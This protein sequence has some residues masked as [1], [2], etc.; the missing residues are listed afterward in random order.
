MA[1]E[2]SRGKREKPK[3]RERNSRRHGKGESLENR[4]IP[5]YSPFLPQRKTRRKETP[6]WPAKERET[7][8][9]IIFQRER[10][11][12]SLSLSSPRDLNNPRVDSIL[13]DCGLCPTVDFLQCLTPIFKRVP[14]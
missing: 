4:E 5:F 2:R 3:E 8:R 7:E 1:N 11:R 12:E 13:N 14:V 6:F 10:E 9:A